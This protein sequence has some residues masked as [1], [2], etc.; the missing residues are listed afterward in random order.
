MIKIFIF[1]YLL[2]NIRKVVTNRCTPK[3]PPS[4]P[5]NVT[6][7]CKSIGDGLILQYNCT[8]TIVNDLSD[9]GEQTCCR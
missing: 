9:P 2:L 7:A 3:G 5:Q 4:I 8:Q 1:V 6:E